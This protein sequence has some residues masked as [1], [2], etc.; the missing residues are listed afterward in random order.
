MNPAAI[1]KGVLIGLVPLALWVVAF[2]FFPGAVAWIDG[3][4]GIV[5]LG[6][7]A[8][9]LLAVLVVAIANRRNRGL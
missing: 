7:L 6:L 1:L 9:S 4:I 3:A 5:Y 8:L 2:W